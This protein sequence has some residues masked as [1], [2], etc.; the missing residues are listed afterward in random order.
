MGLETPA[1]P[2]LAVLAIYW[3]INEVAAAGEEV[4]RRKRIL[5]P[6]TATLVIA[7]AAFLVAAGFAV[8]DGSLETWRGPFLAGVALAHFAVGAWFLRAEGD[9]HLFGLLVTGTGLAALTMAVPVQFGASVVPVAWAAEAVALV[10]IR[11]R[12]QHVYS[13]AAAAVLGTLAIG[14]VLLVEM[15]LRDL[16]A[17]VRPDIPFGDAAGL[18]VL[19]VV[20][21][22]VLAGWLLE[23]AW[24]RAAAIS[25]A[26]LLVAYALPF[27]LPPAVVVVG[28]SGLAVLCAAIGT[29]R[30]EEE[31]W[32]LGY[33]DALAGLGAIAILVNLAPLDRLVVDANRTSDVV[34]FLNEATVAIASVAA[35]LL[36]SSRL[37]P[38]QRWSPLRVIL[39]AVVGVYL[40]S[41]GVVDLFQVR[42]GGSVGEEELA[43]QAQVA[44]SVLWAVLGASAFTIGLVRDLPGARQAG[45]VLLGLVTAKV[46]LVDLAA[47]DVAYRV[48]SLLALGIVLL[49]SAYLFGRF[50]PTRPAV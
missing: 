39:A 7:N 13:G 11:V 30:H 48:L 41:V 33:A 23:V 5:R 20:A 40:L 47:L 10:W 3:A 29:R 9:R 14:H 25:V 49:G 32:W 4:L 44:L 45:L 42:L 37:H 16:P 24:E 1:G 50:R 36:V 35:A 6:A 31:A 21:A 43:K 22:L 38:R 19:F 18:A 8:L 28:W 15:R 12:R 27:E 26:V 2:G 17:L 34:P 46:F